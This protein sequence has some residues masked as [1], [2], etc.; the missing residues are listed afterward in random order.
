MS[1]SAGDVVCSGRWWYRGDRARPTRCSDEGGFTLIELMVVLL[2]LAILLAI[3][4]PTF[5]GVT[6][7]ANDRAAQSNLNTVLTN[8]KAQ[9]QS[10]GQSFTGGTD[11]VS[12]ASLSSEE[13]SLNYTTGAST[14][15][16][17]IS[18]AVATGGNGLVLAALSTS[19][20]CW[21]V[22]DNT[23]GVTGSPIPAPWGSTAT[24]APDTPDTS[25]PATVVFSTQSGTLYA[26][27]KGDTNG[28]DC[29]AS[30]PSVSGTNTSYEWSTGGFPA[31]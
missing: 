31:L 5:L 29:T 30:T 12:T 15:P 21:Y 3:A 27:V 2:V 13:P 4:I 8:A 18:W 22:V 25:P 20:S 23:S 26:E 17:S 11:P 28:A 16:G 1:R 10:N 14:G 24:D 6:V 7:S 19:G 9:F